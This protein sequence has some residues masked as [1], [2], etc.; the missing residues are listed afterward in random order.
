MGGRSG[1]GPERVHVCHRPPL[2][3]CPRLRRR[4]PRCL[5]CPPAPRP[6]PLCRGC[7]TA[8][9]CPLWPWPRGPPAE[10]NTGIKKDTL[11]GIQG[12]REF[13]FK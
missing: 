6:P 1:G 4:S 11:L 3:H 12:N 9:G 5:R 10:E 8:G 13:L 2:S 7:P